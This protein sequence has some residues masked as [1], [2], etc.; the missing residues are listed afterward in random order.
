MENIV[1]EK[2]KIQNQIF[3]KV[4]SKQRLAEDIVN[5]IK[6]AIFERKLSPGDKLPSEK[7]LAKIFGISRTTA[8]EAIRHL[9]VSGLLTVRQGQGGGSFIKEPEISCVQSMLLDLI[10]AKKVRIDQFTTARMLLEP[11]LIEMIMT[12]I[13]Q[14]DIAL[15]EKN[16]EEAEN[17]FKKEK[18]RSA[19]I[20]IKFHKI[21]V[22]CTKNP[23]IIIL[24]N[25]LF[26]FLRTY[27]KAVQ[28]D[29]PV[30][31]SVISSHKE[32]LKRIKEG[33]IEEIRQAM[34]DHIKEVN[35]IVL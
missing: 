26:D 33:N 28:P 30:V 21:L 18:P 10:R 25:L 6:E 14:E 20:N 29:K 2:D 19:I 22:E 27:L 7:E 17:E 15:L 5:Q 32:I 16:V 24:F 12:N 8:R 23:L 35:E 4:K 34:I 11:N 3:E 13:T 31:E 1:K 9:E